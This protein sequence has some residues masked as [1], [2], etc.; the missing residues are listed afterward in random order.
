[1]TVTMEDEDIGLGGDDNTL[2]TDTSVR[3][4]CVVATLNVIF[5]RC[6]AA[7]RCQRPRCV[8][9]GQLLAASVPTGLEEKALRPRDLFTIGQG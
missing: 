2:D 1:M 8:T 4:R 7:C 9:D 5:T 6:E 3:L